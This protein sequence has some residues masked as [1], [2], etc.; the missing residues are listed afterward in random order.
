MSVI[1]TLLPGFRLHMNVLQP[2]DAAMPPRFQLRDDRIPGTTDTWK[3]WAEAHEVDEWI[4]SV[5]GVLPQGWNEQYDSLL[6]S[7]H[8]GTDR[9]AER[10]TSKVRDTT[11]SP[12][13]QTTTSAARSATRSANSTL[14]TLHSSSCVPRPV[15]LRSPP[16]NCTAS[17]SGVEPEPPKDGAGVDHERDPLVRP[18]PPRGPHGQ[19]RAHRWRQLLRR[20]CGPPPH[21]ADA[22]VPD[23]TYRGPRSGPECQLTIRHVY[24]L[25]SMPLAT[26][27][28]GGTAGGSAVAS[29]LAWARSTSCGS[30][31][32]SGRCVQ[33]SRP[34]L[35]TVRRLMCS[36]TGA[37]QGHRR[38]AL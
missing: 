17:K 13:G 10:R 20:L 19:R 21:R 15:F 14:P 12:P 11:S 7:P 16:A 3:A 28:K 9:R 37:R 25:R 27:L 4:Q 31:R 30:A 38:A 34:T 29:S 35:F 2:V 1:Y 32:R 23:R 22:P 33:A 8:D 24:R 36:I 26:R 18:G 5:A 6:S